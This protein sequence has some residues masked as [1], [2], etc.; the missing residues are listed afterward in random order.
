[1]PV[2]HTR[3]I[4]TALWVAAVALLI[5]LG[6]TLADMSR[7]GTRAWVRLGALSVVAGAIVVLISRQRALERHTVEHEAAE[8]ALRDSEAKF[9][10]ILGIAA[11]AIIT[12]D[13][14]QRIIH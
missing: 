8:R 1:M 11:D 3:R 12:V 5:P 9:S 4:R 14:T 2:A 6:I 7:D 10:G 13:Q